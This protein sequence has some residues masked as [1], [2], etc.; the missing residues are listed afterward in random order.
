MRAQAGRRKN[1]PMAPYFVQLR[2]FE[3]RLMRGALEAADGNTKVAANLLGVTRHYLLA[4]ARLLGA[5]IGNEPLHEPPGLA[6]KAWNATSKRSLEPNGERATDDDDEQDEDEQDE[7]E[8]A[9]TETRP[10]CAE[11]EPTN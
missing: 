10:S 11:V 9:P 4:R 5:V 7:Q 3:R 8:D 1:S 6:S 2:E